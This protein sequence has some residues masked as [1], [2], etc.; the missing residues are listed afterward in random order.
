MAQASFVLSRTAAAVSSLGEVIASRCL[1]GCSSMRHS[2][3]SSVE[4]FGLSSS[5]NTSYPSDRPYH[6][7]RVTALQRRAS[8]DGPKVGKLGSTDLPAFQSRAWLSSNAVSDVDES[9]PLW[10]QIGA[11]LRITY[12]AGVYLVMALAGQAICHFAGLDKSG[13][14]EMCPDVAMQGLGFAIPPML[15]LLFILDDEVVKK[16]PAARAIRDVEDEELMT[17]FVG[18]SPWQ[19]LFV[20]TMDAVA[21][22]LFFRIAIQGGIAHMF[23]SDGK[24]SGPSDGIAAL[25]GVFPFF[26]PFAH[27][28]AAV[29]TAALTGSI[30]FVTSFPQD[31]AYVITR[32]HRDHSSPMEVKK[33]FAAWYERRQLR[34]IYSPLLDSLLALYLGFEWLQT[35]NILAPIITHII[36][37]SVVVGN[38][39]RRIH[40]R[41]EKLRQRT[42]SF[43]ERETV[44]SEFRPK[45]E[46]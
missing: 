20:V 5:A 38:G 27:G 24:L 6:P 37:S 46:K 31:P 32:V 39:L 16:S 10:E 2:L 44:V 30:L 7:L 23:L 40:D 3:G 45:V 34:R 12:A 25:T 28:L 18:M 4:T 29:L 9:D 1:Q 26:A 33:S 19:L 22:E 41:R 13:G 17:F 42:Q 43:W 8:D 14:F 15:A 35:G 21:E 36:Y 11:G